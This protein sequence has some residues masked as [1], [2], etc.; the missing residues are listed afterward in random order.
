MGI[1]E[2]TCWDEHWLLYGNQFD[3]KKKERN[4][5]KVICF[6]CQE[7]LAKEYPKTERRVQI[8][9]VIYNNNYLMIRL[10]NY[11][12]VSCSRVFDVTDESILALMCR[13]D[14]VST[15]K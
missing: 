6:S 4:S 1:E 2:G 15:R 7:L 14:Q 10:L 3:N 11:Q 13:R 12:V 5:E 8:I 9:E